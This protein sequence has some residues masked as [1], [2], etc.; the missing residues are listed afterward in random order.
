MPLM[1]DMTTIRVVVAITTPSR[2]RK[3]RS[4]CVRSVSTAIRKPSREVT[5][6]PVRRPTRGSGLSRSACDWLSTATKTP[7][8]LTIQ[9]CNPGGPGSDEELT[10]HSYRNAT[11]G[12]R[13]EA[14]TAGQRPKKRPMLTDTIKPAIADQR[15]TAEG[16][17]G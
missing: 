3:E 1:M 16:K 15:G 13:R 4:L 12:S 5:Q 17:E 8:A 7:I 2:V 9:I 6:M 10:F 11:M 14:F